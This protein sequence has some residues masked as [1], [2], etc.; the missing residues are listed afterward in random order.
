M[1]AEEMADEEARPVAAERVEGV[2]S[3][4]AAGRQRRRG[5]S[6]RSPRAGKEDGLNAIQS[7]GIRSCK[8]DDER[9]VCV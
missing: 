3:V 2:V 4:E 9:E 8:L 1:A 5:E 6:R 7:A